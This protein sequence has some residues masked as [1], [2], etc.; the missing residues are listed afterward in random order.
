VAKSTLALFETVRRWNVQ[1]RPPLVNGQPGL[2][3]M[4]PWAA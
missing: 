4:T 3:A 2:I 1:V